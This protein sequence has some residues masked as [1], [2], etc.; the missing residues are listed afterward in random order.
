MHVNTYPF[1][2]MY[3]YT[4]YTHTYLYKYASQY[5]PD[6]YTGTSLCLFLGI[7]MYMHENM[8]TI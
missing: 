6:A 5:K 8:N 1:T 4:A 3:V 7:H 2:Y